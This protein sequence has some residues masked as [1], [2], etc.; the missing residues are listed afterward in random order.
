VGWYYVNRDK[1][2]KY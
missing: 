2:I 1:L